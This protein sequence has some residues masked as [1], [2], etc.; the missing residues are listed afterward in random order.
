[1]GCGHCRREGTCIRNDAVNTV[2]SRLEEFDGFVFGS[3]VHYAS[4][5]G[6]LSSFMDRLFYS[7]ARKLRF[8]PAA[9]VVS[10]R[11]GGAATALDEINK[12]FTINEMPLVSSSYWNLIHGRS[13]EEALSDEEGVRTMYRLG[14][15]MA[16]ILKCM[17]LAA[18]SGILPPEN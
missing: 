11:R 1:M 18:E 15:N 10:C 14:R 7:S 13:A 12:Y 2:A 16:Y 5:T 4:A 8:K 9:A 3:A 6:A 17:S